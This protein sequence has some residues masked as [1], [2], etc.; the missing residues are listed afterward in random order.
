MKSR[1]TAPKSKARIWIM[2]KSLCCLVIDKK[3]KNIPCLQQDRTKYKSSFRSP[4]DSSALLGVHCRTHTCRRMNG[5]YD[6]I[7]SAPPHQRTEVARDA[8]RFCRLRENSARSYNRILCG[9]ILYELA[10]S[11]AQLSVLSNHNAKSV[12]SI[13]HRSTL[14]HIWA[15]WIYFSTLRT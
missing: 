7:N 3:E 8:H 5:W 13:D 12:D 4:I 15:Q 1:R 10:I 14:S 9:S 6:N 11:W 2:S